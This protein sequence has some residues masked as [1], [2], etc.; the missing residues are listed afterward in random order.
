MPARLRGPGGGGVGSGSGTT[1]TGSVVLNN[2]PSITNPTFTT[3]TATTFN[4]STFQIGARQTITEQALV[5]TANVAPVD[6]STGNVWVGSISANST[7]SIPTNP[8]STWS[9]L[10]VRVKNTDASSRTLAFSTGTNGFR[11]ASNINSGSLTFTITAG[12]TG[13]YTFVWNDVDNKWDIQGPSD[14]AGGGSGTVTS[15]AV[16]VPAILSVSGS[17]VT[18]S[19]TIAITTATSPTGSGAIVLANT[20][21]LVTPVIGAATGTSVVLT[22]TIQTTGGAV[23]GGVAAVTFNAT[24]PTDASLGNHF[25]TTLTN[26]FTLANP[27]NP[28]NGQR[29]VWELIQDATGSRVMTLDSKWAL[30]TDITATT[31][32]TTA[33][34]RDFLTAIYNLTADKWYITGFVKGY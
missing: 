6:A 33:S 27:T 34:K 31:L 4:T 21:T 11:A 8:P 15:V 12:S 10:A 28:T 32:T 20:P 1:G 13:L 3:A 22:G 17:P 29:I 26:N 9:I 23:L 5:F 18:T 25:R 19:G 24:L 14:A 30:G 16:S 7:I 2:G